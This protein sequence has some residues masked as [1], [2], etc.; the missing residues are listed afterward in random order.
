MN[1][2]DFDIANGE[3]ARRLKGTASGQPVTPSERVWSAVAGD[4]R[5]RMAANRS[6]GTDKTRSRSFTWVRWAVPAVACAAITVA[7]L[8]YIPP[9]NSD[10][11]AVS[12]QRAGF[13]LPRKLTLDNAITRVLLTD[14]DMRLEG[15]IGIELPGVP[16]G[17]GRYALVLSGTERT[18]HVAHFDG[19]IALTN[20]PGQSMAKR[21]RDVVGV[22]IEGTLRIPGVETNSGLR[23]AYQRR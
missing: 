16:E 8:V 20:A 10:W 13:Q 11:I 4:I 7:V 14:I 1:P 22:L 15:S 9:K 21:E 18:N 5:A 2:D 23:Q 12:N 6:R 3:R 17:V 19:T